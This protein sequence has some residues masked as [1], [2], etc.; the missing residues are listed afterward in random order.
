MNYYKLSGLKQHR[1]IAL[2]FWRSEFWDQFHWAKIRVLEG[3]LSFEGFRRESIP[4]FFQLPEAAPHS[5]AHGCSTP[6]SASGITSTSPPSDFLTP[7]HKD[8]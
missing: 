7:F 5:L 4:Y 8:T 6:V 1:F 3:L 2:Y